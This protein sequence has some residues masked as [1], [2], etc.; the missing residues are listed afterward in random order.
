MEPVF[1]RRLYR[2]ALTLWVAPPALA[3]VWV[4]GEP[5]W[6][7][8]YSLFVAITAVVLLAAASVVG[9]PRV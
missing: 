3:V 6:A 9:R 7:R 2:T 1:G 4:W 5:S 8:P